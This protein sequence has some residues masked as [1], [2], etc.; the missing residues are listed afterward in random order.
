MEIIIVFLIVL[1]GLIIGLSILFRTVVSTNEVHIVQRKKVDI[2]YWKWKEAGNVYYNWPSWIPIIGIQ[3]II[4]PVSI[5]SIFLDNYEAY[6]ADK[7]PFVV[8]IMAFF[9]IND[10]GIAAQRVLSIE[11]LKLQLENILQGSIRRI[12]AQRN[13]NDILE[14]RWE[15]SLLFTSEVNKQLSDWWVTTTQNVELMNIEDTSWSNV[16]ANIMAMKISEIEKTSRI[17]VA[18]NLQLAETK[19]IEAQKIIDVNKQEAEKVVWEKTAEKD[20]KVWIAIE[21]SKQEVAEQSK[22]TSEKEM[23]VQKVIDVRK[24][25][26]DKEVAVVKAQEEKEVIVVKSEW[27][28]EQMAR[29][30]EWVL[31]E[32]T[33]KSEWIKLVWEAQAFAEKAMQMAPVEAQIALAKEIWSNDGYMNYLLWLKWFDVSQVVGSEKAKALQTA[34]LKVISTSGTPNDW[35]DNIMDLFWSKWWI[36]LANGLEMLQQTEWGKALFEKFLWWKW[37]NIIK[38]VKEVK[39]NKEEILN[40]PIQS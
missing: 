19:E 32:E 28:K 2:S 34:D 23:A 26:I 10:S 39:N 37:K 9:K 36:S 4:L 6:D 22:I 33:K 16:I 40:N 30:A 3:R 1:L 31:I 38:E 15:F 17:Q 12:L 5:F 14:G 35:V 20:K 27:E 21:I 24:A 8:D 13:I 29:I 25:E 11:E 18:E 7:V